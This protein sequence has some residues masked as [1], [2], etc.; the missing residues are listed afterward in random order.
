MHIVVCVKQVPDS[1]EIRVDPVTQTLLREGVPSIVNVFDQHALEAAVQLR[2]T[3]GPA[4]TSVQITAVSMG[5]PMAVR[6]LRECI[7]IGADNAVLVCDRV[8]A[9]ADTLATSYVLAASIRRIAER[10][11][12]VDLVLCGKQTLD[13]DTGQVGPGLACRL[14]LEPLT[15]V[16]GIDEVDPGGQRIRVR[17]HL[18]YGTELVET[19]LPALVAV[20]ETINT[21]RRAS[22]PR[23]LRG[24]RYAP[25]VWSLEDFPDLDRAQLGL[26]GS[27]TVVGKAWVAEALKRTGETIRVTSTQVG[28][29][30]AERVFT[31]LAARGIAGRLGWRDT[32]TGDTTAVVAPEDMRDAA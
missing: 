17:R 21:V 5:P 29:M 15:Y 28:A 4:G 26:K 7:A 12:T 31:L 16:E 6:A 3:L 10:W 13:G 14:D 23:I 18:D 11:G 2:E 25:E 9:G 24:V 27:P 8:F 1:R 30:A 20:T 32:V 19:R 22:L